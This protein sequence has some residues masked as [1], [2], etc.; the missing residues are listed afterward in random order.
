MPQVN[1]KAVGASL[2]A[3]IG[4]AGIAAAN[5]PTL[6]G[7]VLVGYGDPAIPTLATACA[8]V[9][10]GVQLGQKYSEPECKLRTAQALIEIGVGIAPCLPEELP[11][12]TRAAFTSISYNIG[13]SAFCNSTMS[14]LARQGDLMGACNQISRWV[15]AAGQVWPGLVKRRDYERQLCLSGLIRS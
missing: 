11:Q 1:V 12:N 10:K 14:R 8:G 15:T 4:A 13:V 3:I 9:T 7:W 2:A 5:L 6:E